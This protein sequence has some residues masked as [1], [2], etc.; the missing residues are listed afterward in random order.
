MTGGEIIAVGKAAEAKLPPAPSSVS[1]PTEAQLTAAG[2]V[3]SQQ[4]ASVLGS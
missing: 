2:N 1:F 3:V 4:W